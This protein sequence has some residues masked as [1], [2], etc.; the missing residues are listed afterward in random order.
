MPEGPEIR[1]AADKLA[2]AIVG[3]EVLQLSFGQ[4]HLKKWQTSF[5]GL[6][7]DSI[8]TYGKAMVTRFVDRTCKAIE[9]KSTEGKLIEGKALNI[10]THNQLYGRWVICSA[11]QQP[12]STR[13]LRLGIY[14]K[15]KWALLYSASDILVL[16]DLEVTEHPFI[17]KLGKDVLNHKTTSEYVAKKLLSV[18]YRNRQIGGFLT[19][20]SF[21]AGLGNYLRCDIL[22][23]TGI[24]PSCKPSQ[25]NK[26]KIDQLAKEILRLPRQAYQTE[27]ITRDLL[28]VKESVAQGSS[29]EDARFW[30][31]RR[32][33]LACY[34]C[35]M[36]I[37]KKNT[38]GQP[39][40]ICEKCQK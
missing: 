14:T 9:G 22:F 26:K 11:N 2:N 19:E 1:K 27:S 32:E 34:R 20:Q 6:Q 5:T 40:Y 30:V 36:I 28:A 31:F 35:G 37:I 23:V 25:L 38:G 29:L 39:C 3:K 24:H 10:Y 18:S 33:G 12:A 8:Q 21:V 7:V 17:K 16:S 13:Q 15:N 4:T